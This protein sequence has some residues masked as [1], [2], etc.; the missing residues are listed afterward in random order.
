MPGLKAANLVTTIGLKGAPDA[1]TV[2]RLSAL[3]AMIGRGL[4]G[5]T[6]LAY[7]GRGLGD[8]A[9]TFNGYA[10]VAPS[11]ITRAQN[12]VNRPTS[13]AFTTTPQLDNSLASTNLDPYQALLWWRVG[14]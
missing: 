4:S 11:A 5:R 14:R 9:R 6:G 10:K 3:S 7:D 2:A 1:P 13:A 12:Q 8:A